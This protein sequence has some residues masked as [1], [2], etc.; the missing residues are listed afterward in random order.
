MGNF[1]HNPKKPLEVKAPNS[2]RK[3]IA[4][5]EKKEEPKSMP[6]PCRPRYKSEKH[7]ILNLIRKALFGD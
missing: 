6:T 2:I 3:R 4:M 1:K 7:G 5:H